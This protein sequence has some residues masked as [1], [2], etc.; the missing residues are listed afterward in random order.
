[1]PPSG[2]LAVRLASSNPKC[3]IQSAAASSKSSGERQNLFG[4]PGGFVSSEGERL[5]MPTDTFQIL[6]QQ[7]A[8]GERSVS[9]CVE[10]GLSEIKAYLAY[11]NQMDDSHNHY[12]VHHYATNLP[13]AKTTPSPP[14]ITRSSQTST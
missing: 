12:A 9:S 14:S 8:V 2:P 1:M 13:M 10:T 6:R 7:S 4:G 3:R 5:F 11:A